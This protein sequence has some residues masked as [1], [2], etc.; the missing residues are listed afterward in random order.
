MQ[1]LPSITDLLECFRPGKDSLDDE[2][3]VA[4]RDA[5]RHSPSIRRQLEQI[6]RC[7]RVTAEAMQQVSIPIG[8]E[9]RL[10]A[11]LPQPSTP[12][13]AAEFVVP[14][15]IATETISS[16]ITVAATT[17]RSSRN[18]WR[19]RTWL[20]SGGAA[21]VAIAA[22]TL[23]AFVFPNRGPELPALVSQDSL[24]G[25][26]QQWLSLK[27]VHGGWSTDLEQAPV[28]SHPMSSA[29]TVSA[30]G[31]KHVVTVYDRKAVAYNLAMPGEPMAVLYV[32][33]TTQPF[34]VAG[35]PATWWSLSGQRVAGA[36]Q[37]GEHLYVL[38]VDQDGRPAEQY[39]KPRR[40]A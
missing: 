14:I 27:N 8:L 12:P 13:L 6:E 37:S 4:L 32:L 3:F 35:S 10:L 15:S 11:N 21:L 31:W 29:V 2:P 26:I 33:H 30:R 25:E 17:E 22:I 19:R 7:D 28:T 24:S 40:L 39:V 5:A 9:E 18:S 36:W 34:N 38:V 20:A 16:P 23:A 1:P